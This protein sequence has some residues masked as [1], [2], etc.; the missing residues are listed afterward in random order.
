MIISSHQDNCG[1]RDANNHFP[2]LAELYSIVNKTK[3]GDYQHLCGSSIITSRFA[4][5]AGHCINEKFSPYIRRPE[6]IFLLTKVYDLKNQADSQKI[7]VENIIV[8]VDWNPEIES[9]D[10]DIAIIKFENSLVFSDNFQPICLWHEHSIDA[11]NGRII[12]FI[13]LEEDDPGYFSHHFDDNHNFPKE[14]NMPIRNDCIHNQP[15]FKLVA[16]NRTYCAGGDNSGPC[17]E[18]GSSGSSMAV[19]I[20][21]KYYIR[22]IVSSSFIDIAGC[23][24]VT[25]TLF[26]DVL[27]YKD[28]INENIQIP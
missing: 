6:E 13:A 19:E 4:V 8:H 3:S 14:Y 9:Y 7:T 17:L 18:L 26:T 27:K 21:N 23:D 16:S 22:G 11:A 15:R 20:D 12:T 5:T 2:W 24:N 25:Y 1:K 28:W 10:G